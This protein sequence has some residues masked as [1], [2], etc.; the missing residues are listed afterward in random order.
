MYNNKLFKN[1]AN[2]IG[3]MLDKKFGRPTSGRSTPV[4]KDTSRSRYSDNRSSLIPNIRSRLSG[5]R[6][7]LSPRETSP[8]ELTPRDHFTVMDSTNSPRTSRKGGSEGGQTPR[9]KIKVKRNQVN[10][11]T[12]SSRKTV[13]K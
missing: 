6:A 2:C 1:K 12:H 3:T 11:K 13:M 5:G 9:I 10:S 8:F 4:F 7:K